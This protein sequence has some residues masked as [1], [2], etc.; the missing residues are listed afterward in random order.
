VDKFDF[1]R[2]LGMSPLPIPNPLKL[3]SYEKVVKKGDN[4]RMNSVQLNTVKSISM[5][6]VLEKVKPV[7][8]SPRH[9]SKTLDIG[10][11][12]KVNSHARQ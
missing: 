8:A 6:N 2:D 9:L 10:K 11:A 4:M 12:L 1:E 5:M 7:A 3:S